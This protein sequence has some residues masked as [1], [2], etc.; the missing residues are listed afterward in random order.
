VPR[1]VFRGRH[2]HTVD[3][4]GRLSIPAKFRDVLES[5]YNGGLVVAQFDRCLVTYPEEEWMRLEERVRQLPST[6]LELRNYLRRFFSSGVDC[7]PDKQ[8]RILLP[9]E[10]RRAAG[11]AKDAVLVGL[12]NF[13]EIWSRERW[14][15]FITVTDDSFHAMFEKLAQ[16]GI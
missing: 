6:Q 9:P 10:L 16:L 2:Y 3:P 8:G 5:H 4:K 11:I 13:F 7:P 1:D 14:D 12:V 15:E